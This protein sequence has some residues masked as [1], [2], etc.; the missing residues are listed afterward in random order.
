MKI[1][2]KYTK[3]YFF[4]IDIFVKMWY[5]NITKHPYGVRE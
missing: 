3:K 1:G 5:H 2:K 4:T